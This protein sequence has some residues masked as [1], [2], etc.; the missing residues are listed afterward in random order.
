AVVL[1]GAEAAGDGRRRQRGPAIAAAPAGEAVDDAALGVG[2]FLQI[3]DA[4][5]DDLLGHDDAGVAGGADGLHLRDRDRAFVEIAA[6]HGRHVAP[7]AAVG[8]R[9]ARISHRAR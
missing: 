2:R 5:V 4:P 7:A 6:V 9:L 8:L 1:A 3:L